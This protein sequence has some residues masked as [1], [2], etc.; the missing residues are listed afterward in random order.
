MRRDS[1]RGRRLDAGPQMDLMIARAFRPA[2][3]ID[4]IDLFS[5]RTQQMR[6]I[7]DVIGQN[8]QHAVVYGERG[9]GKTSLTAVVNEIIRGGAELPLRANCD[10]TDN[11]SLIWTK[12]LEEAE[13]ESEFPGVGFS[14][15]PRLLRRSAAD[16][17]PNKQSVT[18]NDVRRALEF[19]V[20]AGK[21]PVVFVDEFD[22][23]EDP[24]SRSLFADTIKALSD[25]LVGATVV[26]VGVADNVDELIAEHQSIERAVVQIHM[27]RMSPAELGDIVHRGL[28][29]I[30]MTIDEGALGRIARLSQGLPHYTHLIA[31]W[32][33]RAGVEEGRAAINTRDVDVAIARA[34][35]RAQESVIN[36]YHRATF[37]TQDNLYRQVFLACSLAAVD[38]LGYFAAADV[39]RPLSRIMKKRYDIP[40]FARHLNAMCEPQR[41]P[42][43]QKK[44]MTRNFRFRFLN[45]LLQPYVIMR[46]LAEGMIDDDLL[47]SL[48]H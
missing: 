19:L 47:E 42:V 32:A 44:G 29:G 23:L 33:A 17:L 37:S 4:Q 8:G 5:G 20:R 6:D 10:G 31:Q 18:P 25:H 24:S 9:V 3:P 34:L 45:P 2:A 1:R 41:G 27:P 21:T 12:V 15:E 7:L 35:E 28:T 48:S 39:R 30:K 38:D 43:L 14:P 46:G 22:R 40:S 36:A 26:I 13:I 16:L 11:F